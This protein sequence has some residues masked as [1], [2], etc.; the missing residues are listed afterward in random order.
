MVF[1]EE[2]KRGKHT[3]FYL[4]KTFREKGKVRKTSIFLGADLNPMHLEKAVSDAKIEL[5]EIDFEKILNKKEL[6]EFEDLKSKLNASISKVES[7]G[8]YE[9]FLTQF[10]YDSNAIEGSTLT[11]RETAFVLFDDISP[12]GKPMK[13]VQ[14][15][16]NH[17]EAF[18]FIMQLKGHRLSKD[19]LCKIQGQIVKGTLPAHLTQF[20]GDLRGLNVRV[21]NHIAP[22]FY[23]VPRKLGAL[24]KWFNAN[25]TKFHPIVIASYFHSEFESIHP[26]VDG[27]GR[28]GRLLMNFM[29]KNRGF[30]VINIPVKYR[31]KYYDSL[32]KARQEKNLTPL[33]KIMKR[34]YEEMLK[35]YS[36]SK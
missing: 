27:N 24:I 2:R 32:E 23:S 31:R 5:G 15:A 12:L 14:E 36:P 20:E 17:K 19:L 11:L 18:D 8:F 13:D 25:S 22:P 10:T 29:L 26:F 7:G 9:H 1:V 4:V 33:I 30:P 21:G 16:K 28:T 6:Q 35:T 34:S 3:Y